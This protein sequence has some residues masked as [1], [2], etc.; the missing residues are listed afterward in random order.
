MFRI[1]NEVKRLHEENEVMAA[2]LESERQWRL[3]SLPELLA[4]EQRR[5]AAEIERDQYA[6]RVTELQAE[7]ERLRNRPQWVPWQP[8]GGERP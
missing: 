4:A 3:N 7:V 2:A 1:P 6:A 5:V 8:M